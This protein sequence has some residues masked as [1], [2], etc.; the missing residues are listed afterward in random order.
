MTY[1]IAEI[2]SNYNGK[3][4]KA[5][6]LIEEA[7]KCGAHAAKF[8][9][10]KAD[11]LYTKYSKHYKM[12]KGLELNRKWIPKLKKHCDKIGID[13]LASVFDNDAID[14]LYDVGIRIFKI[15]SYELT[16]LDLINYAAS[17][18][19]VILS[20]GSASMSDIEYAFNTARETGARVILLQCT[21]LYPAPICMAN[22][23]AMKAMHI[24]FDC[25]VGL[26]DHTLGITVPV[27]A[28][29]MGAKMI[30]KHFTL[31]KRGK[32][33]DHSFALEP[34]EFKEMAGIISDMSSILG[35][36]M[37][38]YG[39]GFETRTIRRTLHAAMDIKKGTIITKKMLCNKRPIDKGIKPFNKRIFIGKK[40]KMNVKK[41]K[42]ITWG[43]I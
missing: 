22:L 30:E 15:A 35:D 21:S 36:G 9:I 37:K 14:R 43:I 25:P 39:G 8:Q 1:I 10:F 23:K 17:K 33:P 13:F 28:A 2:G 12:I 31:D 29:A 11:K 26:S 6:K 40:A 18:G 5:Y 32:G 27:I 38:N 41:D 24:A 19:N 16:D 7:K 4:K 34:K 20:T 42:P 3:L